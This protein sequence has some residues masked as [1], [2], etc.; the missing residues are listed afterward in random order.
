MVVLVSQVFPNIDWITDCKTDFISLKFTSLWELT[1]QR[2]VSSA[3][4]LVLSKI[5]PISNNFWGYDSWIF[6]ARLSINPGNSESL[7]M[8][9][10]RLLESKTEISFYVSLCGI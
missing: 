1:A 7:R 4:E 2:W 8:V 10:S 6:F 5:V 3:T 9:C